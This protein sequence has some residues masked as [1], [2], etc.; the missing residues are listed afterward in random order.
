MSYVCF[1]AEERTVLSGCKCTELFKDRFIVLFSD[2]SYV[3]SVA[4]KDV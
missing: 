3:D 1:L 2:A 4:V